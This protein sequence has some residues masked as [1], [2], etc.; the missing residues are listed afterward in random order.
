MDA[1]RGQAPDQ[2]G[3]PPILMPSAHAPLKQ[4]AHRAKRRR[5][6]A[7]LTLLALA[8]V[9]ALFTVTQ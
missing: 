8:I 4:H 2:G 5:L 1:P 6:E 3:P 9:V 7:A